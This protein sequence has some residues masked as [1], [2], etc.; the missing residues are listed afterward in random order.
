MVRCEYTHASRY[1]LWWFIPVHTS[2]VRHVSGFSQTGESSSW[3]CGS[4]ILETQL[5]WWW[6]VGFC[7]VLNSWLNHS[8]KSLNSWE[9]MRLMPVVR[10]CEFYQMK[11]REDYRLRTSQK[12]QCSGCTLGDSWG[13]IQSRERHRFSWY[14]MYQT[15][16]SSLKHSLVQLYIISWKRS[17]SDVSRPDRF[18]GSF[19]PGKHMLDLG[20][21]GNG[22]CSFDQWSYDGKAVSE[23][24]PGFGHP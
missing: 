23:F 3:F 22:I 2:I 17:F 21:T 10:S 12:S 5:G 18:H 1:N 15:C 16:S 19:P 13:M 6:Q 14:Q 11:G 4:M 9:M 24:V 20:A 8:N 7:W